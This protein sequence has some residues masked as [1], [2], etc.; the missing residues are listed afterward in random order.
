M[1]A[2]LNSCTLGTTLLPRWEYHFFHAA[3]LLAWPYPYYQ[4][5]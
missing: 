5:G 1:P 2:L 3:L 4:G